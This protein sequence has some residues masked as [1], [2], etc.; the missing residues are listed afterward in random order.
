[1]SESQ[2]ERQ[3]TPVRAF[4]SYSH[5]D[6]RFRASLE[7][8]LAILKRNRTLISWDDKKIGPG[9]H[10][11]EQIDSR[12]E[13]SELIVLLVSPD[14][15]ASEYCFSHELQ[16]AM[17]RHAAGQARVVPVILRPVDWS[18][19]PFAKLKALPKDGKP[20]SS[21]R[22]R[23]EAY[24]DVT[25]GLREVISDL[26]IDEGSRRVDVPSRSIIDAYEGSIV[27]VGGVGSRLVTKTAWLVTEHG[28]LDP[29]EHIT[30]SFNGG[31]DIMWVHCPADFRIVGATSPTGNEVFP[32]MEGDP[33]TPYGI[34]L[35]DQ[36][37]NT[38]L[39]RCEWKLDDSNKP[40]ATGT[41]CPNCG[42]PMAPYQRYCHGCGFTWPNPEAQR[43]T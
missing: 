28:Y 12:L 41:T 37:Q 5:R 16:M 40:K 32:L 27:Q 19:A 30:H 36:V 29:E 7:A 14:F 8:H 15:I 20:I 18:A 22:N 33:E 17:N 4:I 43:G 24:L 23:D 26:Q 9:K 21:W 25:K 3:T 31:G 11:D 42:N 10:V 38:I 13:N 2:G 34:L 39:I 35:K 1:M 6:E